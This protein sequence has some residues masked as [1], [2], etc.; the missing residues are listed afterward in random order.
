ME[1]TCAILGENDALSE[2]LEDFV[3][4]TPFLSLC[5]V[6]QNPVEALTAYYECSVQLY[7]VSIEN[8]E[9]NGFQ[10]CQLLKTSTR[11]I[12]IANDKEY[13]AD[14]FRMNA[15]DYLLVTVTYPV[16]LE[17][18]SKALRWFA[19]QEQTPVMTVVPKPKPT[20]LYIKSEYRVVRLELEEITYI[21]SMGDYIKICFRD[22]VKPVLSLCSMKS[23]ELMLPEEDFIRVHRSYIVRKECIKVL[24][25][26]NI[27]FGKVR[28]P[29]GE[30]YRKCFQ[31]FFNK[32]P[33]L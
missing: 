22:N 31:E 18:V 13:A 6:Y 28:V 14:C 2:R 17:A 32:F 25:R 9:M 10:F 19:M 7:F 1:L 20:F 4:R 26:G 12:F 30:S 33:I 11:V 8:E 24:E 3:T 16:F 29:I 15:L 27:V 23:L 5:G 21:E